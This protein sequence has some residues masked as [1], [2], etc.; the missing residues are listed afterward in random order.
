MRPTAPRGRRRDPGEDARDLEADAAR[1][2]G[3]EGGG[4]VVPF[5]ARAVE[6]AAG[7]DSTTSETTRHGDRKFI[8][9]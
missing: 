2:A 3:D 7:V 4:H 6:N 5:I 1:R 8:L 9:Q